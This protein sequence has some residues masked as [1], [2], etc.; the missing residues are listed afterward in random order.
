VLRAAIGLAAVAKGVDL[1]PRL[2]DARMELA[3]LE[4]PASLGPLVMTL[5]LALALALAVGLGS[6]AAALGLA[7]LTAFLIAVADL[8]SNHLY[9][10]GTLTLLLGLT[11]CG[12]AVSVDARLRGASRERVSRL[13]VTLIQTQVSVVYLF[14]ALAKVNSDFVP[15]NTIFLHLQ[16]AWAAPDVDALARVPVFMGMAVG[17]ILLEVFIAFAL[18]FARTR[19]VAFGAGLALHAGMVLVLSQGA[20]GFARLTLF[21][22]LT[23]SCFLLF[24]DVPPGGR[25]LVWDEGSRG[26]AALA[27]WC[28]RLDWLGALR[29]AGGGDVRAGGD[30]APALAL[31]EPD[32]RVHEGF[33]ALR[34]VLAVLPVSF[35]WA[36]YLG[37]PPLRALGGRAFR[38]LASRGRGH[39]AVAR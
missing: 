19:P 7:A 33:E 3:G 29:P 6:R 11:D 34:R 27:R 8:Y 14:S 22:F 18:W 1:M 12:A 39:V 17:A 4:V 37:L 13:P 15:G 21:A 31:V 26:S 10:L 25:R 36:P 23:L 5:W 24:L 30:G 2:A 16:S 28:L 20:L 32:G 9:F 38:A 35:L